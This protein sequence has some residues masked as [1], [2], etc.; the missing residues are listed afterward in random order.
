[1]NGEAA[2]MLVVGSACTCAG[3]DGEVLDGTASPCLRPADCRCPRP[4]LPCASHRRLEQMAPRHKAIGD[5]AVQAAIRGAEVL[6]VEVQAL[7]I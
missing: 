5:A 7:S 4:P 2:C 1:M 6:L 3:L